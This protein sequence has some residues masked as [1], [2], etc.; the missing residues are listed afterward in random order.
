MAGLR[1]RRW[2]SERA[3]TRCSA[4]PDLLG[5]PGAGLPARQGIELQRQ[6][7]FGF[8]GIERMQFFGHDQ[9]Q[10]PVAEKFQPLVGARR[11]GAGMGQRALAEAPDRKNDGRVS[12]PSASQINQSG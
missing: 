3:R 11:I 2:P 7:A 4:K 9:P 1:G 8:V 10:H 6:R 5:R 12:V